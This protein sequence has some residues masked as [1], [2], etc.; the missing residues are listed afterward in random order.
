[1]CNPHPLYSELTFKFALTYQHTLHLF[2]YER[3]AYP[4]GYKVLRRPVEVTTESS[5]LSKIN[6]AEAVRTCP[7]DAGGLRGHF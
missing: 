6:D 3:A 5:R 2:Y 1:M 4:E 7:L